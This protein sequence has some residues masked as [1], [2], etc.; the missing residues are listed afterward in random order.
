MSI[1]CD[2]IVVVQGDS[3]SLLS[4]KHTLKLIVDNFNINIEQSGVRKIQIVSNKKIFISDLLN[5]FNILDKL[6]MLVEGVFIPVKSIVAYNGDKD[7]TELPEVQKFI[8]NRIISTSNNIFKNNSKFCNWYDVIDENVFINWKKLLDELDIIHQ[9]VLYN[10]GDLDYPIDAKVA[11]IIEVCEALVEIVKIYT[12]KF[13]DLHPGEKDTP[14]KKCIAELINEYGMDIFY[15]EYHSKKDAFLKI[16]KDSRTRIMHIKRKYPKKYFNG[17]E[18]LI[19]FAKYTFLYRHILLQLLG[20]D[21]EKYREHLIQ[22]V[23]SLDKFNGIV[24]NMLEHL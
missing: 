18:S 20:I 9:V 16:S 3:K 8:E 7:V 13:H 1:N 5:C 15:K 6:I 12:G 10:S 24:D 14:L 4:G 2:S 11:N 23:A 21:Y 17:Q 19:Y 22:Y